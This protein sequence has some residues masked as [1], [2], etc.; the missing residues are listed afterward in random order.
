MLDSLTK[1][2]TA[3]WLI[4]P[5]AALL[6]LLALAIEAPRCEG[7]DAGLQIGGVQVGGCENDRS[8]AEA[9]D[10]GE[11]GVGIIPYVGPEL[12]RRLGLQCP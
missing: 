6:I 3:R 12:R 4:L 2:R 1:R 7:A 11:C 9:Y 8:Q 10:V 5:A